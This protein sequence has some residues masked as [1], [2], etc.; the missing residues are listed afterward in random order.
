[1]Y[2]RK[3]GENINQTDEF[4]LH[5]GS[6]VDHEIEENKLQDGNEQSTKS[7]GISNEK[8]ILKVHKKSKIKIFYI[9]IPIIVL[10]F[11]GA[12]YF[13]NLNGN[14]DYFRDSKWGMSIDEV[15]QKEGVTPDLVEEEKLLFILNKGKEL[16]GVSSTDVLNQGVTYTFDSNKKLTTGRH[17]LLLNEG[18]STNKVMSDLVIVFEKKYGNNHEDT[19][20]SYTWKTRKSIITL[21]T[22]L[23]RW[24]VISYKQK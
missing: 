12:L 10:A 4:C 3:C 1:M 21:Q 8:Q 16:E 17:D 24:I 6:K 23:E 7:V 2:C 19:G 5:C 11:V 15:I 9:L 20:N 22:S 14:D 18:V 13:Y